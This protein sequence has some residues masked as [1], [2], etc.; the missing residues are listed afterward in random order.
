MR[1]ATQRKT[2]PSK[3]PAHR[4]RDPGKPA[5]IAAGKALVER[6]WSAWLEQGRGKITQRALEELVH[7]WLVERRIDSPLG[8]ALG[9]S[10]GKLMRGTGEMSPSWRE[11]SNIARAG[12]SLRLLPAG[13]P[14]DQAWLAD[15]ETVG[16]MTSSEVAGITDAMNEGSRLLERLRDV[17]WELAQHLHEHR[18]VLAVVNDGEARD[19]DMWGYRGDVSPELLLGEVLRNPWMVDF[20]PRALLEQLDHARIAARVREHD[21]APPEPL[22]RSERA[23][24]DRFGSMSEA[25]IDAAFAALTL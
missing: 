8:D 16:T 22:P 11:L 24:L 4:P 10:I 7:G 12:I 18:K 15:L 1:D 9:R 14:S 23:K 20:Q 19:P 3:R 21:A 6:M 2:Q 13:D 5:R 25:E 17:A